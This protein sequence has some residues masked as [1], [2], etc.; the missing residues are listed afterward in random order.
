MN[1]K[2]ISKA[3]LTAAALCLSACG[4]GGGAAT[5]VVPTQPSPLPTASSSPLSV[6]FVVNAPAV[7]PNTSSIRIAVQ[8]VNGVATSSGPVTVAKIASGAPGCTTD[9]QKGLTCTIAAAATSGVDVFGVSTYQSS[10]ASGAVL[11]TATVSANASA[12]STQSVPLSLG[13]VP[14]RVVFSPAKLPL[15]ADGTIH[16]FPVTLNVADAS[17]ATIVGTSTY[18]SPVSLQVLNDPAHAL[19]LSTT[20]VS[21]PGDVVTVTYDSSKPLTAGQVVASDNAM[22]PGTLIAAPLTI[23]PTPLA[24]FDDA[25]PAAVTLNEGGFTGT[26]TASLANTNDAS[27]AVT[28]GTLNSGSAVVSV[29]PK[30]HFDTTTLNVS[31]GNMTYGVPFA[32]VPHNSAYTAIGNAHTLLVPSQNMVES[33]DGKFWTGDQEFGTL[34]SFD[35]SSGTYSSFVVDP[36][37]SGPQSVAADPNGN[38]WFA[39][40]S[41][42]GKY[43]PSTTALTYYSTGLQA[44]PRITTIVAGASGTMWFYDWGLNN[45]VSFGHPTFF[46]TIDT[47]SGTIQEYPAGNPQPS[48][49]TL[50]LGIFE[51]MTVASDNSLWFTDAINYSVGHM[52]PSGTVQEFKLTTP[53]YPQQSPM[54]IVIAPD[55]KVWVGCFGS[56]A[57]SV[58]ASVD[59]NNG[60]AVTYYTTGLNAGAFFALTRGSDG[61]LWFIQD[62]P[63]RPYGFSSQTTLGVMNPA[64]GAIYQYPSSAIPDN[65]KITSMLDRGDGTLWMLDSAFG[66]IGKVTLK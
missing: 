50:P 47:A 61:N 27:I 5:P 3:A 33:P 1:M 4:G 65:A 54:Q 55:G 37:L 35:P 18:Q 41:Q 44:S 11:A 64:S 8:S 20:S 25:A 15:I 38:I 32:V 43:T 6:A 17:G 16:R 12:G 59:P 51:T 48:R 63:G 2:S 7:S 10:D 40:G 66:R 22:T 21:K 36:S 58:I 53:A 57:N 31:D 30:V 56:A 34:V 24:V 28:P 49:T 13:G 60:N 46:G 52:T 42:I 26:F 29:T 62:P 14:A 23:N 9:P 39:D 45:A 19:S